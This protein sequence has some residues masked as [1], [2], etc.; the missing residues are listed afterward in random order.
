[1]RCKNNVLNPMFLLDI[2][3]FLVIKN[4]PYK[5]IHDKKTNL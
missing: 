3:L 1:M 2:G 4:S 5:N